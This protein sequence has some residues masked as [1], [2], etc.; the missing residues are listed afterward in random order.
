MDLKI[1]QAQERILRAFADKSE[2]FALSGGSAL[3]LYYLKHRFSVDLDFFSPNYDVEEIE[4]LASVFGKSGGGKIRFESEFVSGDRARVRFYTMPVKGSNR[5]LKIDF[6]EDVLFESPRIKRFEGVPVYD[7]EHIYFQKIAAIAG[8]GQRHDSLG[9]P[10]IEGAREEA[11][12]AFDIYMLSKKIRPLHIFLKGVPRP[13]QRGVVQW[14][15]TFS[16]GELKL[17]LLDLDIYDNKF[18]ARDMIVY[19]ESEIKKFIKQVLE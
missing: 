1:R 11:R 9:R 4:H 6:V 19:L 5:L 10:I 15:Q 13:M 8:T 3:E 12:D 17:G 2:N 18:D 16:R 14:Y 7:V